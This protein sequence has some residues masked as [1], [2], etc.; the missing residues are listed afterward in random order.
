MSKILCADLFC[1]GGGTSTGMINAFRRAG[2][3]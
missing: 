3:V 1:G 2:D